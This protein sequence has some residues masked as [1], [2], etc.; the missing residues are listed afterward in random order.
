[1]S[2]LRP[3]SIPVYVL[4]FPDITVRKDGVL[5]STK[6][7][8]KVKH[9]IEVPCGHCPACLSKAQNAWAF[10]IENEVLDPCV[11]SALFVTL[12]Y[13]PVHLPAD[14]SVNKKDVQKYLK[15]LRVNLERNGFK[16]HGLRYYLCG[17]YGDKRHRP[18]YH[19]ILTF[20]QSVD[21]RIVQTSWNMGIVDIAPFTPA[22]G[23]YVAKYSLKQYGLNYFGLTPPFRLCSKGLGKWF[24]AQHKPGS[25]GWSSNF[26][27]I[28]GRVVPL[29]RYYIDKLYPHFKRSYRVV[30][31]AGVKVR[32][33]DR[34]NVSTPARQNYLLYNQNRFHDFVSLS[35]TK[36]ENGYSG[37]FRKQSISIDGKLS[38]HSFSLIQKQSIR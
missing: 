36:D 6:T 27:N 4:E 20:R 19:A 2:C 28:S 18:H 29:H 32:V 34:E 16:R 13:D 30:E 35:A 26:V 38:F 33:C 15:R 3:I 10:R 5:K 17:E 37:F 7:V 25:F 24:L 1:M 21:W 12:T 23:G 11:A 8:R 14:L 9:Y 22:R 31:C